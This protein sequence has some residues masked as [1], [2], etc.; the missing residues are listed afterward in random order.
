MSE[1]QPIITAP[2]NEVVLLYGKIDPS[3]DFELL[4]W[5][6]DSIFSGYWDLIDEAWVTS[7][8]TWE[9]PFMVCTHWQPLPEAPQ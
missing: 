9:G 2:K 3:T 7:G 1:W 4:T 6:K 8:S 5:K